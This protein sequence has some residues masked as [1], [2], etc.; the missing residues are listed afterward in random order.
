MLVVVWLLMGGPVPSFGRGPNKAAIAEA[1]ERRALQRQYNEEYK[2]SEVY[3]N[4]AVMCA[5]YEIRITQQKMVDA[6]IIK[7]DEMSTCEN[8]DCKNCLA[9]TAVPLVST[10][11]G[12]MKMLRNE[13][14]PIPDSVPD[15]AHLELRPS[16]GSDFR[17][18]LWTWYDNA[19]G[20]TRAMKSIYSHALLTA[21]PQRETTIKLQTPVTR[22]SPPRG[23]GSVSPRK[24]SCQCCHYDIESGIGHIKTFVDQCRACNMKE[25]GRRGTGNTGPR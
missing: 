3:K 20:E 10:G 25:A 24:E 21:R 11:S 12:R 22:P 6:G 14:V 15:N 2:A 16:Y 7:S 13:H 23:R 5:V 18:A 1:D 8:K 19:T 4:D 9:R 17:E